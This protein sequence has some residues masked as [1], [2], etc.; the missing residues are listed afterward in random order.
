MHT[1]PDPRGPFE[2][3]FRESWTTV[4]PSC[5]KAILPSPGFQNHDF[6]TA[7]A[8]CNLSFFFLM[9]ESAFFFLTQGEE[10]N[11]FVLSPFARKKNLSC[12]KKMCVCG[13]GD[14]RCCL[15]DKFDSTP[16]SPLFSFPL[17][18]FSS[19]RL[20]TSVH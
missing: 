14:N 12:G 15:P 3:R 19:F 11:V 10:E 1:S 13:F 6:R 4:F 17:F 16:F 9:L 2:W 5:M 20:D 7:L 18:L 8:N